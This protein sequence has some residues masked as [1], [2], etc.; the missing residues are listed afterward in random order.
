WDEL[1]V[2]GLF[3]VLV[4]IAVYSGSFARFFADNGLDVKG[5]WAIQ[6]GMADY[7]IHLRAT[8]PYASKA[9]TWLLMRRPVAYYYK[10][11]DAKTSAEI[12]GI[13]NPVIFWGRIVAI[14]FAV[15]AWIR[16]RDWRAV[17]ITASFLLQTIPWFLAA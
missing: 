7:S 5:W 2:T 16:R 13:G 4:P 3:L 6:K 9:W 1:F 10:G 12:L 11:V 8:H 14:P 15:S 17:L